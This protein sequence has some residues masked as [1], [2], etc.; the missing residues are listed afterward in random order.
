VVEGKRV[1]VV[2]P[3]FEEALLVAGTIRGIP[4]F[5]DLVVVVD[6]CSSD[7]T[8]ERA[9]ET[10]DQRLEVIRHDENRGV[11]AAIAT[12]YARC[13]ELGVDVTCVMAADNQ[14]DP[15]ELAALVGPV[16]RGEVEYAKANRL[17]SGEAWNLI[18]R[19]RYLG[20]AVL[21]L[22]T[23]IAS[24]YWHV[25]DS[26]AGYTAVSLGALRRLDLERLYRRYGFPNDMLVHLNVQNARVRDVPSRPIYGVGEQSG[27][28]VHR[29]A[30]RIAWLLFKG[31]WWR[32]TQKYVIRDFH[33]L[34]F[35]Y[36]LGGLMTVVGLVLG[37]IVACSRI[38]WGNEITTATVVLV[39]LLLVSGT[40]FTLFAMWFD[41]EAN[42]ELR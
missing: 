40:Q 9:R 32:M 27:I 5:V 11:G 4:D 3:A 25:A 17:V 29:V 38:F 1:A 34:V 15:S 28:R 13:R 21:S 19:A 33:P 37:V 36:A 2:V 26:Q 7:G 41:Q 16:A 39:A 22:L 20:N 8:V 24:G 14:M 23:K 31:F 18:P 35:F 30:P 12:G 6:D 10:R 42:K